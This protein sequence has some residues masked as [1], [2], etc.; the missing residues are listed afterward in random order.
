MATLSH[1]GLALLLPWGSRAERERSVRLA[2]GIEG[3]QV[4]ERQSLTALASLLAGAELVVGVDTGL[5]H[6]AAA[7][8]TPTL[9]LFTKTD[10]A[11]AGVAI[12]GGHALDLGG[13]GN[14]PALDDVQAAAAKLLRNAPRC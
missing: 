7:L 4:P 10:P 3:A 6:L 12:A 9:A 8:R 11:G 14:V 13:C 2:E 5:T 1:A